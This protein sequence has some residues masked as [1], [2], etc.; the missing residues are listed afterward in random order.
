M[1]KIEY[2]GYFYPTREMVIE[3]QNKDKT[4]S[5][6]IQI[7][8]APLYLQEAIIDS[9]GD[10]DDEGNDIDVNIYFYVDSDK[11]WLDAK[12][13]AENYLDEPHKFVEDLDDEVTQEQ[14]DLA[15]H[16]F[17]LEIER[18]GNFGTPIVEDFENNGWLEPYKKELWDEI[19]EIEFNI[20]DEDIRAVAREAS[21]QGL[22]KYRHD[23][24][25][26]VSCDDYLLAKIRE[27]YPLPKIA[28][29]KYKIWMQVER[30]DTY[31][32]GQERYQDVE[33]STVSVGYTD[34]EQ[35]A[36]ELMNEIHQAYFNGDQ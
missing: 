24:D 21:F 29:T 20:T 34:T 10:I 9:S 26:Y 22:H 13:I 17:E 1:N 18:L 3:I 25:T 6:P 36:D 4:A 11:F 2:K 28:K 27:K 15:K 8:I 7:T 5:K 32:D 33:E 23:Y 14:F 19:A 30:I 12:T 16:I 31:D 35:Q